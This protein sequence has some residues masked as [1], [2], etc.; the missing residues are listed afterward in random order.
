LYRRDWDG[1]RR[2]WKRRFA[3]AAGRQSDED[4][5]TTDV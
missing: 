5:S 4:R 3:I 1:V 2:Q